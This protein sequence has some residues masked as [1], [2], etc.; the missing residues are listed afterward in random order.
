MEWLV[1]EYPDRDLTLVYSATLANGRWRGRVFMGHDATMEVDNGLT[2]RAEGSSTR[3]DEKINEG[4]IDPSKPMFT[5]QPGFTGLDAIT[6]A[7]AE[8]F[9]RRGLLYTYRG[10]RLTNAY[11]LHIAEWLDVIRNGG[12]TSCD[13]E[14]GYEEAI[15]CH[16]AT[17]SYL[18]KRQ[19]E[20]DPVARR[21]V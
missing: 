7:T 19:V 10:G 12:Q 20:W 8:Y 2:I 16:M 4:V 1:L 5:F 11:H 21:I 3:F 18:E 15:A 6:S 9:A 14:K 17:R 13:I